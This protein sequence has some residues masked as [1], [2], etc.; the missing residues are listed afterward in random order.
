MNSNASEVKSSSRP[1]FG[2]PVVEAIGLPRRQE[3]PVPRRPSPEGIT[4]EAEGC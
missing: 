4:R 2:D 3:L 1:P